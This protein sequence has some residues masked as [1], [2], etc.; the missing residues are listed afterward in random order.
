MCGD[1]NNVRTC[2]E[3]LLHS[4]RHAVF[5]LGESVAAAANFFVGRAAALGAKKARRRSFESVGICLY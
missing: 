3:F 4:S 5:V 1:V 2:C